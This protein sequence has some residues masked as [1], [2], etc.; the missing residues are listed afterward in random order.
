MKVVSMGIPAPRMRRIRLVVSLVPSLT[1]EGAAY[2]Y[3][4]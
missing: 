3:R 2:A 4:A 1:D